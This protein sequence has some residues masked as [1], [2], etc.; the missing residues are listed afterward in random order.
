MK[1][2]IFRRLTGEVVSVAMDKTA[3]VRVDSVKTHKVY[4][5]KIK[6]NQKYKIHDEKNELKEGDVVV[7]EECRPMSKDKRWRLVNKVK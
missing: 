1:D 5:K 3:V 7:F 4:G 2:K 6:S